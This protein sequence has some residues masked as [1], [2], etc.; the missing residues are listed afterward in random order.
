MLGDIHVRAYMCADFKKSSAGIQD[1]FTLGEE[2]G[3]T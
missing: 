1:F 3:P 2:G